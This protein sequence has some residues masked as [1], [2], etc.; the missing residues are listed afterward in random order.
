MS[1]S[2]LVNCWVYVVISVTLYHPLGEQC[3]FTLSN[4]CTLLMLITV[5]EKTLTVNSIVLWEMSGSV[6]ML[7]TRRNRQHMWLFTSE[8]VQRLG[9]VH[10]FIVYCLGCTITYFAIVSWYVILLC[11]LPD[12]TAWQCFFFCHYFCRNHTTALTLFLSHSC[13]TGENVACWLSCKFYNK[14]ILPT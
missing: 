3:W 14:D 12:T 4:L 8:M 10:I 2:G 7:W 1:W 6:V 5:I 11:P 13:Q 9:L